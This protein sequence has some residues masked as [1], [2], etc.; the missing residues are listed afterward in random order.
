[1]TDLKSGKAGKSPKTHSVT[2]HIDVRQLQA[3]AIGETERL[4]SSHRSQHLVYYYTRRW[5]KLYRKG[6]VAD[7][8]ALLEVPF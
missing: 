5:R 1:M 8:T 3:R 2:R 4:I 7:N 6:R